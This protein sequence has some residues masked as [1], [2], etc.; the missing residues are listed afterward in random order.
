MGLT[1]FPNCV[2]R[3]STFPEPAIELVAL[4]RLC[5]RLEPPLGATFL[6]EDGEDQPLIIWLLPHRP[7]P[8]RGAVVEQSNDEKVIVWPAAIAPYDVAVVAFPS[9]RCR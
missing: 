5:A 3:S 6:D 1:G 8:A 2:L 7:L 4:F 9:P